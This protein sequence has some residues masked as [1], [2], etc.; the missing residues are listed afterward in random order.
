MKKIA[1]VVPKYGLVGGGERFVMEL[2]ERLAL[3][4]D[5]EIHVF[6]NRWR[7]YSDKIIFHKVPTIRFPRFLTT[8]SFAFFA[9]RQIA[10][11]DFDIVHSHER[12]FFSDIFTLHSVPH[13]FWVKTV[14]RKTMSLFDIATDWVEKKMVRNSKIF[15]PVSQLTRHHFSL[16]FQVDPQNIRIVHP[17]VDTA[18][19]DAL[20]RDYCR[21][22]IRSRH[23]LSA[24]DVVILFVGM[25]FEVKGL[26]A[27]MEAIALTK[28]KQL[29][30]TVKLMVVGKG[31]VRKYTGL[32]RRLGIVEDVVFT[33]TIETGIEKYYLASDIFAMPSFFDTFGMAVLEAFAASLP[34][35]ISNNVGAKDLV[36]EDETGY[37]INDANPHEMSRC[38]IALSDENKREKMAENAYRTATSNSWDKTAEHVN[39]IYEK[40]FSQT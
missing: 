12:I 23:H 14:R 3:N 28:S 13:R 34:V 33:G 38:I 17:G 36:R 32:A 4:P 8:I 26:D 39:Q 37:I 24:S 20:D 7:K 15:I 31:N 40:F 18:P 19:F 27:I 16:R 1:V 30:K 6:A 5:Y 9:C 2:T 21:K 11:H 25:N 22:V 29:N 10:R 35:L